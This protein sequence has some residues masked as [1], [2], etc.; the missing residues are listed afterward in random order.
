MGNIVT[1]R[2]GIGLGEEMMRFIFD[3]A[4][5]LGLRELY[6]KVH[7]DNARAVRLYLKAGFITAGKS[8]NVLNLRKALPEQIANQL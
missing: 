7:R 4:R 6:L 1:G 5:G 2:I 3:K 8:D